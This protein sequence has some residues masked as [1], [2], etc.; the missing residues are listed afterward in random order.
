MKQLI[1]MVLMTLLGTLGVVA[2]SPFLGVAVY[3]IFAVLRPQFIWEWSLPQGITWSFYV[4]LA[5][6]LAAAAR[7]FGG[8]PSGPDGKHA[9][10]TAAHMAVMAFGGWVVVCYV[11]AQN[12]EIAYPWFIE[13]LKIIVMF[14]ASALLICTVRHVWILFCSTACCLGYIAYEVN[15]LYFLKGTLGI[16]HHGYG[17]LDNNGAG[18]ML[19]MGVPLCYFVWEGSQSRLRWCFLALLPLLLHAV[20]MTYSRGAMV[21]LLAATPLIAWRSR[22]R[23]H[24]LLAIGGLCSCCRSWR[25]RKSKSASCPRATTNRTPAP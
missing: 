13:Y 7:L 11:M 17:G 19:A 14:A 4:A 8:G 22:H 3:Y 5:T 2:A 24:A 23:T 10:F 20:L 12:R 16:Y 21:S 9:H 18:L 6:L 15:A 1:F 25:G